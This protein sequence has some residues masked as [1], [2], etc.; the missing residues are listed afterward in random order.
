LILSVC[1]DAPQLVPGRYNLGMTPALLLLAILVPAAEAAVTP[2][3]RPEEALQRLS[4]E[5]DAFARD[6]RQ[7]TAQEVL[8][9]RALLAE[10]RVKLRA[11]ATAVADRGPHWQIHEIVSEYGF[12]TFRGNPGAIHEFRQVVSVDGR[13]VA[14]PEQARAHLA[15]GIASQ[16]DG[17]KQQMLRDFQHYGLLGGAYDF[18]QLILLFTRG[19]LANYQFIPKGEA[20]V[21]ADRVLVCDFRQGGGN[22]AL[23]VFEGKKTVRV[24]LSGTIWFRRGDWLPLRISL[25]TERVEKK[26]TLR[27]EATV[28]YVAGRSGGVVPASILHRQFVNDEIVVQDHFAYSSFRRFSVDST[29]EFPPPVSKN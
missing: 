28:D 29:I 7:V 21:G 26:F 16:D 14:S 13:E 5:A 25:V 12:S 19:A 27:D 1:R 3:W 11:G 8:T 17:L 24:P 6:A 23:T 18:G 22:Q 9:Q 4:E 20:W 15:K 2:S 10:P